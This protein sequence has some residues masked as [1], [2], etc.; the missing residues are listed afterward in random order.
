MLAENV[1]DVER[2]DYYKMEITES[3]EPL[4][5]CV[6][7]KKDA[8]ARAHK[9]LIEIEK[10]ILV[11]RSNYLQLGGRLEDAFTD[12]AKHEQALMK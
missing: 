10:Q 8:K 12:E 7:Q 2:D 3:K 6:Q 5:L 4:L 1:D 11:A 9:R